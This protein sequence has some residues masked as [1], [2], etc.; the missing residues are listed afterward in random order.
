VPPRPSVAGLCCCGQSAQG[1]HD[2]NDETCIAVGYAPCLARRKASGAEPGAVKASAGGRHGQWLEHRCVRV[3]NPAASYLSAP[4]WNKAHSAPLSARCEDSPPAVGGLRTAACVRRL[5]EPITSFQLVLGVPQRR[6]PYSRRLRRWR[7][8]TLTAL[9]C[10]WA[11]QWGWATPC[12]ACCERC[13]LT[14]V[15]SCPPPPL[16]CACTFI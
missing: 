10:E 5:T 15:V 2:A 3:T 7:T 1:D 16:T 12:A 8:L 14:T 9:G 13:A 6:S 4:N 11:G